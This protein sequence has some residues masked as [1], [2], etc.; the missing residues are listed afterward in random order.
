MPSPRLPVHFALLAVVALTAGCGGDEGEDEAPARVQ[1][2]CQEVATPPVKDQRFKKPARV[3]DPGEA[4][5]ATVQ[6]SCGTFVIKLDTERSPRT[7]NS[8]A[9]L[10]EQGFYDDTVFHRVAPGFVIQGGDPRGSDPAAAGAGGPGYSVRE[11]PPQRAEYTRGVVAMAKTAVEP[12]GTSGSQFFVVTAPADAG[13]P[14]D[15]AILGKVIHGMDAVVA[16]D[17]LGDR[18]GQ[19]E[20]P[21]QTVVIDK[22]TIE[23]G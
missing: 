5:T 3:L 6:T 15:Y 11:P 23:S 4:A 9:F 10:A 20:R 13:L 14:P 1:G 17:R 16:I 22:V 18:S 8:F 2:E 21:T 12:P 19:T 7:A